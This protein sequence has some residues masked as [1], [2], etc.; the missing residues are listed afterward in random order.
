MRWVGVI[1]G[2][3]LELR[4]ELNLGAFLGRCLGAPFL[5][6][7]DFSEVPCSGVTPCSAFFLE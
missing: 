6:D 4:P 3:E 1:R 7:A 2:S 5:F